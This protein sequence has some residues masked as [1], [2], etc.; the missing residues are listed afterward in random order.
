M[1]TIHEVGQDL[2]EKEKK[3]NKKRG[4]IYAVQNNLIRNMQADFRKT[5]L[6]RMLR[7]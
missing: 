6:M 5:R 4:P 7:E 1:I 3:E 2:V